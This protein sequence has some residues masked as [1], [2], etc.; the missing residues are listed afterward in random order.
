MA[1]A[2]PHLQLPPHWHRAWCGQVQNLLWGA[3]PELADPLQ[4]GLS[5]KELYEVPRWQ[6]VKVGIA[7]LLELGGLDCLVN[8]DEVLFPEAVGPNH[9]GPLHADRWVQIRGP[10][11][12]LKPHGF[13]HR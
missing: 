12:V 7:E 11:V 2:P 9:A 5:R 10:E 4:Y 8:I 6:N 3:N 13:P 1:A